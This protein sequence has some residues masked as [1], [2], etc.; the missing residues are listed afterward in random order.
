MPGLGQGEV[1]QLWRGLVVSLSCGNSDFAIFQLTNRGPFRCRMQAADRD[2]QTVQRSAS[3]IPG[4][5]R[6][7]AVGVG[8]KRIQ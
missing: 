7:S 8:G 3:P 5:G 2:R 1:R 6:R 4:L